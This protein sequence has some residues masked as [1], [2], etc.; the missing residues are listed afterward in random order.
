MFTAG[1]DDQLS[2]QKRLSQV[3][4]R[5]HWPLVFTVFSPVSKYQ[6]LQIWPVMTVAFYHELRACFPSFGG[7]EKRTKCT[8]FADNNIYAI[9]LLF[10]EQITNIRICSQPSRILPQ[11]VHCWRKCCMP[12]I[13]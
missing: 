1:E 3:C 4:C 13:I 11:F 6:M 10:S 7:I 9:Y 12:A 5:T 8:L 2:N